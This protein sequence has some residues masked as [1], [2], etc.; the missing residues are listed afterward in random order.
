MER[1]RDNS[2]YIALNAKKSV[3]YGLEIARRYLNA[4]PEALDYLE[5]NREANANFLA[6][7]SPPPSPSQERLL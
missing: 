4:P 3:C 1:P 6:K 2:T 7:P 5:A